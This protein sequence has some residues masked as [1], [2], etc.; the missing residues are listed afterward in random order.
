M[1]KQSFQP[2]RISENN[3]NQV[4]ENHRTQ[5]AK[6][7]VC[8]IEHALKRKRKKID[9]AEINVKD[10]LIIALSIRSDEFSGLLSDNLKILE[11]VEEYELCALAL[12]LKNKIDKQNEKVTQKD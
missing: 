3:P 9:F 2:I 5:L 4:F 12:K 1:K 6:A 7:I 8:A 11:E 10:I